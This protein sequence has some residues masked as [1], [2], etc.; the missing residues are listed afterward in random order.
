MHDGKHCPYCSQDIGIWPIIAAP[1]P[2][3]VW[4]KNCRT[5]LRYRA[6]YL[7]LVS[8][9]LAVLSVG[10]CLYASGAW[11]IA[12]GS[13]PRVE[14]AI[15]LVVFV[16]G[17]VSSWISVEFVAALLLRN[18]CELVCVGAPPPSQGKSAGKCPMCGAE[19]NPD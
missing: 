5:R 4:C 14:F 8:V 2:N 19:I 10:V 3:R 6:G 1:L 12:I 16:F 18:H 11:R 7:N 9:V 17:A 15:R 13:M